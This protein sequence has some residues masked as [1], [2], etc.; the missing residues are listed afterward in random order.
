MNI[1]EEIKTLQTQAQNKNTQP[2]YTQSNI[3]MLRAQLRF[4]CDKI[5]E[6]LIHA[7]NPQ[8]EKEQKEEELL[9]IPHI[10]DQYPIGQ[11]INNYKEQSQ[12][13]K[14]KLETVYNITKLE[15][16][17]SGVK[18]K[19]EKLKE[20]YAENSTL[21]LINQNQQRGIKE[22]EDKY[23]NK[24]EVMQLGDKLKTAKE[25]VKITKEYMKGLD[26]QIKGQLSQMTVLKEKCQIIKDNIEYKKKQQMKEV[27]NMID[28]TQVNIYH[29]HLFVRK[30]LLILLG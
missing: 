27:Q 23:H 14:Y 16:L 25:E 10:E 28:D 3:E 9:N 7:I 22:Y 11:T 5:E 13:S 4:V 18:T 30:T 2:Q 26:A 19:R 20:K 8:K 21:V 29:N 24:K 17:E 15:A 12:Q 6:T 1:I